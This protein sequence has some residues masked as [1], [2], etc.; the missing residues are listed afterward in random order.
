ME[1]NNQH[2]K[3]AALISVLLIIVG[4]SMV[5]I[6]QNMTSQN[7][8]IIEQNQKEAAN[9]SPL[10]IDA[11]PN[12]GQAVTVSQ[13]E[14]ET[15]TDALKNYVPQNQASVKA[16]KAVTNN[17]FKGHLLESQDEI[18]S[19]IAANKL[20]TQ[21]LGYLFLPEHPADYP[22]LKGVPQIDV[23]L[24]LQKDANWR[25]TSYGSDTTGELGEN[26]CAILSLAM[27]YSA[28]SGKVQE[29]STILQW[30]KEHYYVDNQGT[31]W[32]IFYDFARAF[33]YQFYNFG[34]NFYDAM[35]AVQEG[36]VIVASVKPG[37]FTDIGHILVIR[38]YKD[39][40]VYVNDPNDDSLKMH[41][42]QGID[43]AIFLRDGVNYWSFT[44]N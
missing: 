21:E 13:V 10:S 1:L 11:N 29:P 37:Y 18:M 5:F 23:P 20:D 27:V 12:Q 15:L 30:S 8:L 6:L 22:E 9:N 43:E 14:G 7:Q 4:I 17:L 32:Q 39:G 44:N 2:H 16:V 38:G 31:S 24:L 19:A 25:T 42:I 36:K 26:G 40:K 28:L 35:Q 34:N 3:F 41:S 33:N